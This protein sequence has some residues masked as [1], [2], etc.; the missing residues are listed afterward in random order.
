[1]TREPYF[2]KILQFKCIPVQTNK[3]G[4]YFLLQFALRKIQVKLNLGQTLLLWPISNM[5]KIFVCLVVYVLLLKRRTN[6]LLQ[7]QSRH[8]SLPC[9][10][11]MYKKN[12]I[13]SYF[14]IQSCEKKQESLQSNIYVI[15]WNHGNKRVR[16]IFWIISV[17]M[18]HYCNWYIHLIMWIIQ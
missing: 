5:T 8:A 18:L 16:L 11:M 4:L 7:I 2:F 14:H 17:R 15:N 1:M 13:E 12:L 9:W 6:W 10:H 3:I